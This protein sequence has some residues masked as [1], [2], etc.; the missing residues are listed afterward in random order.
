[1]F[2]EAQPFPCCTPMLSIPSR[3]KRFS[4]LLMEMSRNGRNLLVHSNTFGFKV[5]TLDAPA[6]AFTCD[7]VLLWNGVAS[8]YRPLQVIWFLS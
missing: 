1:M 7:G 4:I 8:A 6:P 2:P 3:T 5:S